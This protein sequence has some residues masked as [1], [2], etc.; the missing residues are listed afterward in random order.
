MYNLKKIKELGKK[1][2]LTG[3]KYQ[4]V[5]KQFLISNTGLFLI[6]G[7]AEKIFTDLNNV[8]EEVKSGRV[9]AEE[10]EARLLNVKKNVIDIKTNADET[11]QRAT[12]LKQ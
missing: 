6:S 4:S 8:I 5:T 3:D 12:S 11:R 9:G 1:A 7:M 10:L 2:Q